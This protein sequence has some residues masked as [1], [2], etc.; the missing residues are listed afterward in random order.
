MG[1]NKP[2]IVG[3]ATC[4]GRE[5][6][7]KQAIKSLEGQVDKIFLYDNEV[8]LVNLTDN[9]KFKGLTYLTE[10][11]YYFSCDDD[12]EYP[13][14]YIKDMVEVIEKHK[15]IVTHHGRIL[16][17]L[18]KNYYLGHTAFRFLPDNNIEK[19]IDIPGTGVTAFSTEYFNPINIYAAEQKR[20]SDLVFAYEAALQGKEITVLKHTRGYFKQLEIDKYQSILQIEGKSSQEQQIEL[21]NKIYKLKHNI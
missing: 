7:V 21:S 1:Y 12:I 6:T 3:M 17:G 9:G 5:E 19:V 4:K 15:T 20:M 10:P 11:V 2:I 14:T 13:S 16:A 18:D 8:E